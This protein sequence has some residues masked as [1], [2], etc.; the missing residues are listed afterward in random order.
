M[1]AA[2]VLAAGLGTRLGNLSAKTPKAMIPVAERPYLDHLAIQLLDGG[3]RPI[4]V[5]IGHLGDQIRNHFT[6][7]ADNWIRRAVEHQLSA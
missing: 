4:V 2:V 1:T 7:W 5:A 3:I 6:Q